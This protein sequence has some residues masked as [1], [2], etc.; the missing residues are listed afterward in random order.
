MPVRG[1]PRNPLGQRPQRF[2]RLRTFG[3]DVRSVDP[4][5]ETPTRFHD[6]AHVFAVEP[7]RTPG[8]SEYDLRTGT[9]APGTIRRIWHQ[10]VSPVPAPPAFKVSSSPFAGQRTIRYKTSNVYLPA[11]DQRS[12]ARNG[13]RGLHTVIVQATRQHGAT[14]TAGV[15]RGQPTIRN[16]ISSFG[17][18]VQPLNP[19]V[20]AAEQTQ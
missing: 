16:R 5:G 7:G 14:L 20:A 13:V 4:V 12:F 9:E 8:L 3:G 1:Q 17:S 15:R 18:R 11:G 2:H 19:R 10:L 6:L